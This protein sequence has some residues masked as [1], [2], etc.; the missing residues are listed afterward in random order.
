MTWTRTPDNSAIHEPIQGMRNPLIRRVRSLLRRKARYEERAVLVEGTRAVADMRAAGITALVTLVRDTE[1]DLALVD[2]AGNGPIRIVAPKLFDELT[3]L[4]HPQG[5]LSVVSMDDVPADP[6]E[7]EVEPELMLIADGMRDPGNLGTLFRSAAGAGVGAIW[8]T[9][10][11]VDPFNPKCV[12]AAMGAHFRIAV[13]QPSEGELRERIAQLDVVAVADAQGD[14]PY[15]EI[16]WS[17]ASAIII[18]GEAF[19]PTAAIRTLATATVRIPLARNIDS[20]NA[21]VAGSLLI[22]EA[23]RQRRHARRAAV[24]G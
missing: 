24:S 15:D 7:V 17:Q 12:R 1:D 6:G 19:G 14:I 23:A 18:G 9:P 5:I 21:G 11:S 20:L 4:P 8:L 2:L 10:D 16:D 3:D 22:F 13:H